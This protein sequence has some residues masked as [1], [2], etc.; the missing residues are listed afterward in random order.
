MPPCRRTVPTGGDRPPARA[1][2][3]LEDDGAGAKDVARRLLS[4]EP[5]ERLEGTAQVQ[6]LVISR[7]QVGGRKRKLDAIAEV[8][9]DLAEQA[10]A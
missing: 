9:S 4:V 6:R 5:G 1:A 2:R 10:P 3:I 7:M 8:I